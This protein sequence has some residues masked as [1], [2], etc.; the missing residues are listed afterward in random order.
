MNDP[1][2]LLRTILPAALAE[3][4]EQVRTLAGMYDLIPGLG[5]PVSMKIRPEDYAPGR[6]L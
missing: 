2:E 6:G 3:A 4:P 5:Q 1:R